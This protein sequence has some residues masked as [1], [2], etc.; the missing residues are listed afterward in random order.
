MHSRSIRVYLVPSAAPLQKQSK[1]LRPT[2]D[3]SSSLPAEEIINPS[4]Q[5][6]GP[7]PTKE[8]ATGEGSSPHTIAFAVLGGLLLIAG[9]GAGVAIKCC[10]KV[11]H[12]VVLNKRGLNLIMDT[13]LRRGSPVEKSLP[14]VRIDFTIANRP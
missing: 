13:D 5:A 4:R 7:S 14:D 9:L 3:K 1:S 11:S 12:K 8:F 6:P 10:L 2:K